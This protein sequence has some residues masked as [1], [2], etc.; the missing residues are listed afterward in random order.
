MN[1]FAAHF[2][3]LVIAGANLANDL[4]FLSQLTL[5]FHVR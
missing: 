2:Y 3:K 5:R 1:I 4:E